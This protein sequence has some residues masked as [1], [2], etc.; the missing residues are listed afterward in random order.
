MTVTWNG[1]EEYLHAI[2]AETYPFD[3]ASTAPSLE[4]GSPSTPQGSP[5]VAGSEATSRFAAPCAKEACEYLQATVVGVVGPSNASQTTFNE[6]L[7]VAYMEGGKMNYHDDGEHGLGPVVASISLG[8]D[9]TMSFRPKKKKSERAKLERG[10]LEPISRKTQVVLKLKLRHGDV[11][12]M[13][14]SD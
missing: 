14:A 4:R 12:V 13:E 1:G 6:I 10:T 9:A 5:P 7:S 11:C 2:A 3:I 8:A